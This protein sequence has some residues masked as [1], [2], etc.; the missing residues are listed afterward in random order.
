VTRW[1]DSTT[2]SDSASSVEHVLIVGRDREIAAIDRVLKHRRPALIVVSGEVGVGKTWLLRRV[3]ERAVRE[4]WRTVRLPSGAL[5]GFSADTT[6]ASVIEL[7]RRVPVAPHTNT[8]DIVARTSGSPPEGPRSY[9]LVEQLRARAPLL[10]IID[11]YRPSPELNTWFIA[12]IEA[13]KQS[14]AT[15][16]VLVAEVSAEVRDLAGLASHV[17]GLEPLAVDAVR[18]HF[19]L[20]AGG[21]KIELSATELD[22][23]V[24]AVCQ[25][26]GVLEQLTTVLELARP[27]AFS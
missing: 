25:N 1:P 4:G 19:E 16:V 27:E 26:M 8:A 6:S 17:I 10:F 14:A 2:P 7:V 5:L 11:G 3:E 18:R 15:V 13:L 24:Q 12:A 9:D 23:Y 22:S 21:L 20:L